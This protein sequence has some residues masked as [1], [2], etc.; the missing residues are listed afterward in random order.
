MEAIDALDKID[1][2]GE[3][4]LLKEKILF[5]VVVVRRRIQEDAIVTLLRRLNILPRLY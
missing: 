2:L 5:S 4:S 1:E 3:L